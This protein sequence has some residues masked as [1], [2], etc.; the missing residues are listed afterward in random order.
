MTAEERARDIARQRVLVPYLGPIGPA[1]DVR[2]LTVEEA[3]EQIAAT[4]R[5]AED[6][7]I[8]RLVSALARVVCDECGWALMDTNATN[9]RCPHCSP[10]RTAL[11]ALGRLKP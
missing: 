3:E 10:T 9:D 1:N 11:R 4:I 8:S 5:A 2:P 7:A 6:D